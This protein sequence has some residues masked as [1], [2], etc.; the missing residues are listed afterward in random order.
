MNKEA[1]K[2]VDFVNYAEKLKVE[3]RHASKSDGQHESVADHS[4]RLALMLMLVAPK[5]KIKIN[6]LRALKIA[7]AHDLVEIESRDV[8]LLTYINNKHL[9]KE[10]ERREKKAMTKIKKMLGADGQEFYDLWL[11]Y[12]KKQTPEAKVIK[13][14]DRLEGELQFLTE[15][16]TKFSKS[17]SKAIKTLLEETTQLAK[18]DPF[19]EAIEKVSYEDRFNRIKE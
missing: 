13:A 11:E 10:K 14:L 6:L 16:V 2:I 7:I 8:P 4:W 5:L 12:E 19:L 9:A 18:I 17:E 3:L 15:S 1:R